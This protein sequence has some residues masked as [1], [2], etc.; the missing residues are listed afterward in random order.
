MQITVRQ[1]SIWT[2]LRGRPAWALE[3]GNCRCKAEVVDCDDGRCA[4]WED[5]QGG[6][7]DFTYPLGSASSSVLRRDGVEVCRSD[8]KH[9]PDHVAVTTANLWPPQEWRGSSDRL[10][11]WCRS[12]VE[13]RGC[14]WTCA[15][16]GERRR[17]I[18]FA[19]ARWGKVIGICRNTSQWP[20]LPW[21]LVAI[22]IQDMYSATGS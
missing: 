14:R 8:P 15:L 20:D 17:E 1:P 12:A 22:L 21:L 2:S 11:S 9:I 13:F 16:Y 18:A 6:A 7:W 19:Q 10:P 5:A 3:V 4:T